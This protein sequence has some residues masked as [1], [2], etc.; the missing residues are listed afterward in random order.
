MNPVAYLNSEI[1]PRSD[2]TVDVKDLGFMLGTTVSERLRTFGGTLFELDAHLQRLQQSLDI[3]GYSPSQSLSEISEA[4]TSLVSTNHALLEPGSDLGLTILITPGI[5]GTLRT[6]IMMY[7]DELPFTQMKQWYHDGAALQ[8]TDYRQV[9]ANC[10]PSELKCRSR[11]HYYLADRQAE[12][13]QR[14]ARALLLDQHGYVAEAST[15]NILIYEQERGLISPRPEQILPGISL[16]IVEQLANELQIP[17]LQED[18]SLERLSKAEEILLCSTSP[19]I[20]PV[21]Q[22]N[23]NPIG[24]PSHNSVTASLQRAWSKLVGTDLVGQADTLG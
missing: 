7:T 15:A 24:P 18:I 11:M 3:T 10:W 14:G 23:G 19:C 4:A 22:C 8:V 1:I 20:W 2:L 9:P 21:T 6:T 5:A 16:S 13:K 17:F 12:L